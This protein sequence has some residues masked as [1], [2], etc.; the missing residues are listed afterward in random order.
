V[1]ALRKYGDIAEIPSD[2]YDVPAG[3][4]QKLL[5]Y[6]DLELRD[7]EQAAYD[8]AMENAD[9]QGPCCCKCWRWHVYG[10]LGKLLIR[11]RGFTGEQL[12][13]VWDLSDGCGGD[14][15]HHHS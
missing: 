8:F 4:A 9:E 11:E 5:A 3:L 12:A 13:E 15:E 10:G 6:Y 7:E 14:G 2:P 1:V